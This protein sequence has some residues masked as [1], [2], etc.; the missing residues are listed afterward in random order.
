MAGYCVLDLFSGTG[1]LGLEALSRGAAEVSF[2]DKDIQSIELIR[3]NTGNLIS[4]I[5]GI[6]EFDIIQ[7]DVLEYLRFCNDRKWDIIFLDPP[8]KI[9]AG[10]MKDIFEAIA[11]RGIAGKD[12]I[13]VYE[14]FFKRQVD[15]ETG[16]FKLV[17]ESFFGDKKVIYLELKES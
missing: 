3:Y 13:L 4:N 10:K 8:Y 12:S 16:C 6:G 7:K 2:V 1:Q 15:D 11:G 17:K 14:F 5:S 9:E